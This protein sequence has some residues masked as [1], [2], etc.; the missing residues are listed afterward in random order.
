MGVLLSSYLKRNSIQIK[1]GL[2]ML[3][4]VVLLS[5]TSYLLY[6]NLSSIVSSIRIDKNPELRLLSVRDISTDLEKAGNSIRIYTITKDPS[7]I[8]PYYTIISRIDDK[9]SK[10]RSECLND[11]ALLLQ[12]DTISKLIEDNIYIWNELLTLYKDDSVIDNLRELS[13]QYSTAAENDQ[14]KGILKRVFNRKPKNLPDEKEIINDI[15][16]VVRKDSTARDELVEQE[17]QLAYTSSKITRKFYDLISKIENEVIEDINSKAWAAG[18]VAK[19]TYNILIALIISGGLLAVIVL[20]IIIKY[21]RN[22]YKYQ[23]AL[24]KAK[25]EAENLSK[26]RELFIANMSHEIRTPLT[27]IS[28]FTEQLLLESPDKNIS[29]SLGVIKSSSDHLLKIIDDILDFSK[30]QNQKLELEKANFSIA[31]ILDEVQSLFE[32]QAQ[33]NN[34]LLTHS[35]DPDTPPALLGDPFRLKQI[36]INLV[37]NS[38]KFTKNGSVRFDIRSEKK[39]DDE[40]FL[41]MEFTDTGI[42][43]DDSKIETVF[44]DFTQ[45]EMSTTRK[46]G[47]TG[48]GLSIVKKL[49]ELHNGTI[50]LKSKIGKGTKIICRIPILIGNEDLLI[51]DINSPV[52]IPDVVTG[53]K[54]L[55]VDDEEYNRLLFS[56]ILD[57]WKVFHHEEEN[58]L[59]AVNELKK[60]RYDIVF[61]DMRMPEMD[62]LNTVRFIRQEMKISETELPVVIV[63]AAPPDEELM[64]YRREGISSFLHK[65][66][67]E[68]MLITATMNAVNKKNRVIIPEAPNIDFDQP[69]GKGKIDLRNLYHI[70]DNDREFVKEMLVSFISTTGTMINEVKKASDEKQWESVAEISHKMMPPCRHLGAAAMFELLVKIER[71]AKIKNANGYI[72]EMLKNVIDEFELVREILNEQIS[73]LN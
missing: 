7:D 28:G 13:E 27:A 34:T 52:S 59:N 42:G 15:N 18:E 61:M 14:K 71:E 40:I 12:T 2:L 11:S 62:G 58:G 37:S 47:G 63:S 35:L 33:K 49:I 48:L 38:V 55:I 16:E 60:N 57:R 3:I 64:D 39:K 8:K 66:F 53:M 70:A 6:K 45:A 23:I 24:E 9:V 10:F 30:L 22:A 5:A 17:S 41:V 56:K 54:F 50:D 20:Y 51:K 43:I 19:K 26:T 67:T 44:E 4:S 1:I 36:M 73:K 65:P 25:D 21:V 32:N 69:S 72:E 68:E 29:R 31:R 46:Y